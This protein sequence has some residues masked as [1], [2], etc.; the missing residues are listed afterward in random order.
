[1]NTVLSRFSLPQGAEEFFDLS[2]DPYETNNKSRQP[3]NKEILLEMR[4][5]LREHM[6]EKSD[7]GLIP[8]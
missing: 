6:V 4:K 7:L 5:V 8:E 3:M 2:K 1:M